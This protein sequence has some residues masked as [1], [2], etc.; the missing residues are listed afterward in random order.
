MRETCEFG[1]CSLPPGY[2]DDQLY[3]SISKIWKF[4]TL[5]GWTGPELRAVFTAGH[6]AC[7]HADPRRFPVESP[8]EQRWK[9]SGRLTAATE[10]WPPLPPECPSLTETL[11]RIKGV[12][13][14]FDWT[15]GDLEAVLNA[16]IGAA[17][18]LRP[19]LIAR[20]TTEGQ[21]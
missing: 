17:G 5:R 12:A 7:R 3:P 9:A 2:W 10:P 18:V 14:E 16:G 8:R 19:E 11:C 1:C 4:A 20:R 21:G 15:A 6:S 13:M